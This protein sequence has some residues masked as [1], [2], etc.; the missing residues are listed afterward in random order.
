MIKTRSFDGSDVSVRVASFERCMF[1]LLKGPSL[2]QVSGR[3]QLKS[4][5]ETRSFQDN[6]TLL[7]GTSCFISALV[8]EHLS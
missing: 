1:L 6:N 8:F 4:V 5:H 3:K 2:I 7:K